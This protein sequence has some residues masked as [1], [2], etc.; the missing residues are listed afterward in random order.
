[1]ADVSQ[2]QGG[3]PPRRPVLRPFTG[4][5]LSA[6]Q[7]A[8]R[9]LGSRRP[10]VSPFASSTAPAPAEEISP[11]QQSAT[12]PLSGEGAAMP[13]VEAQ[14]AAAVEPTQVLLAE[15]PV[16]RASAAEAMDTIG[17]VGELADDLAT[18]GEIAGDRAQGFDDAA[19]SAFDDSIERDS[20]AT[21]QLVSGE[22]GAAM[23]DD[24]YPTAD[25]APAPG[26]SAAEASALDVTTLDVTTREDA[27][28]GN[29]ELVTFD[30]SYDDVTFGGAPERDSAAAADA[31]APGAI[32]PFARR[33]DDAFDDHAA[34]AGHVDGLAAADL[35]FDAGGAG[36]VERLAPTVEGDAPRAMVDGFSEFVVDD[37][38]Y[39]A[40]DDDLSYV[41][42][43][44]DEYVDDSTPSE[45]SAPGGT[46]DGESE[47]EAQDAMHAAYIPPAL[48]SLSED[49][50]GFPGDAP[51]P[52]AEVPEL[53][54]DAEVAGAVA[55]RDSGQVAWST[56]E[57]LTT[58]VGATAAMAERSRAESESGVREARAHAA[59]TL[60]KV[61]ERV[62]RGEI[63]SSPDA[64][65]SPESV[66]ASVL[67]FL[68]SAR[69]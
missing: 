26:D 36:E 1:M 24:A 29:R 33:T 43:P 8:L 37:S 53:S 38:A 21:S 20:D 22:V 60:E 69:T 63:V 61:A 4:R 66:L 7:G 58:A 2:D 31:C 67:A 10:A 39:A 25:R 42:A 11:A 6:G 19:T 47:S 68:L 30:A 14:T 28:L 3:T 49:V 35:A 59:A 56:A 41:F 55:M 54:A 16:G 5:L 9:P 23:E 44:H 18:S 12:P 50:V 15:S 64:N 65:A 57:A 34:N 46:R 62:R 51:L 27:S 17:G 32:D 52:T 13:A 48:L 45:A 40:T